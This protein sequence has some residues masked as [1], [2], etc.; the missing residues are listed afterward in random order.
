VWFSD[1]GVA[2]GFCW[3]FWTGLLDQGCVVV[4]WVEVILTES[5]QREANL[6]H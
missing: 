4:F 5:T 6:V 2:L 3:S 1:L